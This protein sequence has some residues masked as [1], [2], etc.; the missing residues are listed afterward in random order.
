MAVDTQEDTYDTLECIN[1]KQLP[2][3]VKCLYV[4]III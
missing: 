2:R 3:A 4:I 1:I